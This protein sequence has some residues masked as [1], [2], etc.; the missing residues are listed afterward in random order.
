MSHADPGHEKVP[1][2]VPHVL[3]LAMYWGIFGA[4]IVLTVVTVAVAQVELGPFNL[5]VAML[6]ASLKASLVALVFMHL[7][8][9]SKLNAVVFVATLLF[10]AIFIVLTLFDVMTRSEI[11]ATRR[12]FLP[13]DEVV[14]EYREQNPDA[15]PLRPRLLPPDDPAVSDRLHEVEAY[16]PAPAVERSPTEPAPPN[17]GEDQAY[18]RQRVYE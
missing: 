2:P 1:A 10:L 18:G 6:V 16:G 4:L 8:F 12:N 14:Q 15:P 9:D 7:W 17:R 3:P 11:D 13:R 5:P